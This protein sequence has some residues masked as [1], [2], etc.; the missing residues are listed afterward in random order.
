MSAQTDSL[1]PARELGWRSGFGNLLRKE[2]SMR[3]GG[4]RWIIPALVW[5]AILNGFVTLIAFAE[6]TDPSMAGQDIASE[7]IDV[8]VQIGIFA[9][10]IGVVIG[11]QG[12]I[13]REKQLGTAAWILSKPASRSAF[14][15][16]K[17]AAY[18]ISVVILSLALP[19]V[20]FLL[21]SEIFWGK[22]PEPVPFLNACM[23]MFLNLQF[24]LTLTLMLGTLFNARGV[25][26]GIALAFMFLGSFLSQILPAWISSLFPWTLQNLASATALNK[27]LPDG[28][29]V[30]II[31]TVLWL[32]IFIVMALWRFSREEF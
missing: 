1:Q 23:L 2:N 9:T 13:I 24:Y 25:V 19:A 32:L 31:A 29:Q 30:P 27:P 14:V 4:R 7:A 20:F 18:S 11:V 26:A 3:W 10:A 6:K 5:M 21:Q 22:L 28:W 15:L 16:S 12:A 8:F 17:W